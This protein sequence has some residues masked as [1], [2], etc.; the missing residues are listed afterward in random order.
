MQQ[1]KHEDAWMGEVDCASGP[2]P[3]PDALRPS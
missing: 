3:A 1:L 2:P